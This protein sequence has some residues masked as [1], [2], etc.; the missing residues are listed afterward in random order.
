MLEAGERQPAQSVL[1]LLRQ[2][3]AIPL[4]GGRR[5]LQQ[6]RCFGQPAELEPE[7]PL[8]RAEPQVKGLPV[9]LLGFLKA[10]G[11]QLRP[12]FRQHRTKA[13]EVHGLE[14]LGGHGLRRFA[15]KALLLCRA[16]VESQWR[17]SPPPAAGC[18]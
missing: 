10:A 18:F 3:A 13:G 5:D 2:G 6:A 14:R 11:Y 9:G 15:A 8:Q 4:L 7:P 16:M 12:Q 1:E 17:K